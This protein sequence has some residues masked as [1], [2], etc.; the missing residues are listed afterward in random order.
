MSANTKPSSEKTF[1]CETCTMRK[2]AEANPKALM[3][4]LWRWLESLPGSSSEPEVGS[5][6][7]VAAC[8]RP[9]I[10]HS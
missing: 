8:D 7:S 1:A 3:S 6:V 2:N 5:G 4:W 9:I 10:A